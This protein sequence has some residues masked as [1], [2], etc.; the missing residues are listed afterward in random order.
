MGYPIDHDAILRGALN[1]SAIGTAAGSAV[2][3]ITGSRV[4]RAI[5]ETGTAVITTYVSASY[6]SAYTDKPI[7]R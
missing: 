6:Y 5:A 2:E 7:E 4:L 3:N 1:G